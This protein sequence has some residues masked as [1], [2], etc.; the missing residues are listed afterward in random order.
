M[1][2]I[3]KYPLW[4]KGWQ[5][6]C[7]SE[8]AEFL[9]VQMQNGEPFIWALVDPAAPMRLYEVRMVGAGHPTDEQVGDYLDTIQVGTFVWHVFVEGVE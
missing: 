8:G 6:L 9:T 4:I 5:Q 2:R 1:K 7:I 3:W